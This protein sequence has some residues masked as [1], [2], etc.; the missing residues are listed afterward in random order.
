MLLSYD[1]S[2]LTIDYELAGESAT[3]QCLSTTASTIKTILSA[4]TASLKITDEET[5]SLD[6]IAAA[7]SEE[8][9]KYQSTQEA[10]AV[11]QAQIDEA[12]D[13]LE[14][15]TVARG[16]AFTVFLGTPGTNKIPE[17]INMYTSKYKDINKKSAKRKPFENNISAYSNNKTENNQQTTLTIDSVYLSFANYVLTTVRVYA[18][19]NNTAAKQHVFINP[20]PLSVSSPRALEFTRNALLRE[21][22]G[23]KRNQDVN[24]IYLNTILTFDPGKENL[25]TDYIPQDINIVLSAT[26]LSSII[27][28]ASPA[29]S[30]RVNVFTDLT[31]FLDSDAPNGKLQTE[32]NCIIPM[33]TRVSNV[34]TPAYSRSSITFLKTLVPEIC[35]AKLGD[36][37]RQL[38]VNYDPL[39]NMAHVNHFKIYQHVNFWGGGRINLFTLEDRNQ[40]SLFYL[41]FRFRYMRTQFSDTI[42]SQN[43]IFSS[44]SVFYEV[45]LYYKRKMMRHFSLDLAFS[46]GLFKLYDNS[47][48]LSYGTIY[49]DNRDNIFTGNRMPQNLNWDALR[50]ADF[51]KSLSPKMIYTPIMIL[52]YNKPGSRAS[53][54]FLRIAFP[55]S[56]SNNNAFLIANI[57]YIRPLESLIKTVPKSTK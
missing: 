1:N 16:T 8:F 39:R 51:S 50:S 4:N 45:E 21:E 10:V 43:R 55:N 11:K 22:V 57:G 6:S 5:T 26:N 37:N 9:A 25:L 32:V 14:D 12:R 20:R 40:N 46:A 52:K 3:Y 31:G 27:R 38:T 29:S 19:E 28:K 13:V 24:F 7:F 44:M 53:G 36:D 48:S 35:V 49:G 2:R 17:K 34:F 23:K 15:M 42:D 30:F 41:N 56:F 33:R 18:H 54:M 47:L